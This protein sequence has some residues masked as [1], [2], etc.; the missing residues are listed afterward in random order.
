MRKVVLVKISLFQL[1]QICSNKYAL[2]DIFAVCVGAKSLL[3]KNEV[4]MNKIHHNILKTESHF[5]LN[6]S[7]HSCDLSLYARGEIL[8]S[9]LGTSK[10]ICNCLQPCA[11][12]NVQTS[13]TACLLLSTFKTALAVSLST[14]EKFNLMLTGVNVSLTHF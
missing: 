12:V 8:H 5:P 4:K 6:S 7:D 14:C 10:L 13:T 9:E 1:I 2:K 11:V 3:V